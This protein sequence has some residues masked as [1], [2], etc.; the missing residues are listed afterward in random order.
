[1][2]PTLNLL[3]IGNWALSDPLTQA[4]V[5]PHLELLLES[6][7]VEKLVFLTIERKDM[8]D[9]DYAILRHPKIIYRP[10][11]SAM[12]SGILG[13][14]NDLIRFPVAVRRLI[15][16]HQVDKV[17]A[18]GAPAG[19]VVSSVCVLDKVPFYVESFEPH[20][21]YMVESGVWTRFEL[22]TIIERIWEKRIKRKAAGIMPVAENYKKRLVQEGLQE[23]RIVTVPCGVKISNFRFNADDRARTRQSLSLPENAF[24]GVYVGKFGGN[25]YEE[26]AFQL[27]QKIFGVA[28]THLVILSPDTEEKIRTSIK[29]FGL[30]GDRIRILS[31]KHHEVPSYLSASDYAFALPKPSP[32]KLFLSLVKIGEYWANGLPVIVT[33]GIGDDA[34][35]IRKLGIGF[36]LPEH[37]KELPLSYFSEQMDLIRGLTDREKILKEAETRRS[38]QI[39]KSAYEYFQLI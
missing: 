33:T 31:V 4:T 3:Y 39:S 1:M 26:E 27:F 13:R 29:K 22:K 34:E 17:I 36:E 6:S 28:D 30:P 24:V 15:K 32:S 18:R 21:D 10:L 9:Q 38:F 7:R 8:D 37:W 14:V 23:D 16:E 25:Y 19:G 35:H 11:L 2:I 20:A 5:F 12:S